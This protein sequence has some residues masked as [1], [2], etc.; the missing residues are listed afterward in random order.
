[1]DDAA[2]ARREAAQRLQ[3]KRRDL[4]LAAEGVIQKRFARGRLLKPR[5]TQFSNLVG[6]CNEAQCAEEIAN[7]L[8][9][10]AGRGEWEREFTV[11]VIDG[12]KP[13]L[14]TLPQDTHVAAWRLYATYL[15]RAYV[16]QDAVAAGG[17]M[18]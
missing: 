8:R 14:E 1:M 10:Q 4:V 6:L 16:Y 11:E 9:Y 15:T 17:R 12:I 13:M 7:Y 3:E 18:S 5:K 2:K